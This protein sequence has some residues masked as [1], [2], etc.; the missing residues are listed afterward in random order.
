M[1]KNRQELIV[2][3]AVLVGVL[4]LNGWIGYR[5]ARQI[6]ESSIQ[7]ERSHE[8]LETLE[9]VVSTVNDAETGHRGFVIVGDDRYLE[10]YTAASAERPQTIERLRQLTSDDPWQQVHLPRLESLIEAKF[11]EMED[12]VQL[13]KTLGFEI[14]RRAIASD[15]GRQGM[16]EIRSLVNE[17][18]Q[19]ERE[20][21]RE[22]E[23]ASAN[24]YQSVLFSTL[25]A[26]LLG[27]STLWAFLWLLRRYLSSLARSTSAL[28]EADRRKDEFLATLA[29]ELRNPLSPISNALQLWPKVERDPERMEELRQI[30]ERQLRQMTRLIDDLLDV[31]RINSGKI[32]LRKQPADLNTLIAVAIESVQPF[33]ESADQ[34]LTVD[35]PREPLI[36]EGDVARLTQVFSNI[37]HNASKYAGRQGRIQIAVERRGKTALVSISDN[38]PGI[39]PQMLTRIFELFQQVDQTLER[40]HGGLGIGLTLVKRLV[41][42]HGGEVE[43]RSAGPG[44]GSE[45]IVTL[46]VFAAGTNASD[47]PAAQQFSSET[48][49]LPRLK[50]LVVDD[51]R[52]SAKTLAMLLRSLGQEVWVE[53]DGPA[54]LATARVTRPEVIFLDI[55]MPG[56]SGYEVARQVR[57]DPACHDVFLVALTG[58]GQEEDRRRAIEAGFDRHVTKPV[59]LASLEQLLMFRPQTERRHIAALGEGEPAS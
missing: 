24:A 16:N 50:I 8:V 3:L 36:V 44:K 27:L 29:H 57:V 35:S 31:S 48:S 11:D 6:R 46:P 38:G 21:L 34:H 1:T 4:L 32:E 58:Y 28:L 7:V 25:L 14:A 23:Q 45:F 33:V 53:H 43:A 47:P 12:K 15:R 20:R 41:E 52:A 9:R 10:P 5:Q 18:Q 26:L 2:G 13:R 56:M 51:V 17:M 19:H 22:R 55:A 59:S 37:L 42:M 40:S 49:S 54:A 30:M 39:P